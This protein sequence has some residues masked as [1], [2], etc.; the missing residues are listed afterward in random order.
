MG[1]IYTVIVST[2]NVNKYSFVSTFHVNKYSIG[3]FIAQYIYIIWLVIVVL[4]KY[5]ALG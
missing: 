5:K 1:I 2:V 4:Q 3:L